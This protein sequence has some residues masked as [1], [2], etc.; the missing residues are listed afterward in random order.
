M[1]EHTPTPWA[2]SSDG[3]EIHAGGQRIGL[4]FIGGRLGYNTGKANAAFIIRAVNAFHSMLAAL[5]A[6]E[7]QLDYG[8]F[9]ET[10]QSQVEAAIKLAKESS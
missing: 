7:Q 3:L 1:S 9:D 4:T 10:T 8:Q 6:T 5:E 2:S